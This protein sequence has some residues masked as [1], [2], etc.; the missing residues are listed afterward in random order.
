MTAFLKS[1]HLDLQCKKKYNFVGN[2]TWTKYRYAW[3]NFNQ[4]SPIDKAR[5][6]YGLLAYSSN[7]FISG[8]NVVFYT[9]KTTFLPEMNALEKYASGP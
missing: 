3:T 6:S 4:E 1:F 5:S 9:E 7:I 2:L 8:K